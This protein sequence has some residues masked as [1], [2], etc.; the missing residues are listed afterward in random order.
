MQPSPLPSLDQPALMQLTAKPPVRMVRGRGSSLWD[1]HERHYL[2]FVQ[3]WAVNCLGHSPAVIAAALRTQLDQV[4]NPG[5]AYHNDA[6]LRLA[7]RLAQL[8][9]LSRVYLASSGAEANEAA[10]KLARKWAHQHKPGAYEVI[11]TLDSFHGRTLAM[12]SATGKPGFADAYQPGVPG[13]VKVPYGDVAA[14]RDAIGPR[15]VAV[16]VEPV[17]GEAGVVVPPP[18]YLAALRALCDEAGILLILD[19]VQTGMARTGALFA[20][21][22]D[23]MRPD[24]LTLGKGLGGGLPIS[25]MLASA[26]AACFVPGDH[27]GTF[28][29]H[30]LLSAAALAI[31]ELLVTPAH[32]A[33]REASARKLA[34]ALGTLAAR[35]GLTLRGRGH[36]WAL[37]LPTPRAEAVRDAAFARGLLVNAAR[38]H[39]L[40]L[41]PALDVGA[42]EI[43]EMA[44]RLDAA[45]TAPVD[46]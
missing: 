30:A 29:A 17:Q 25:A 45:L 41:M 35:H 42:D 16:M 19:E 9:G 33:V 15:T 34:A 3:G 21:Q 28:A 10:V 23:A 46:A 39:V 20:H 44:T 37:A 38:P 5:P 6:S 13:F 40:R 43:A 18:G 2:D 26:H 27:G 31:V 11:T 12:T 24:I 32:A 8:S 22:H 36:L 1:Q 14:V 7:E 4:L